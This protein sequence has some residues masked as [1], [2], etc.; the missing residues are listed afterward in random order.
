MSGS[1]KYMFCNNCGKQGHMFHRCK[2][3]ITSIGIIAFRINKGKRE[4][5]MICRRNSLGYVD[6]MRG[7][8][9]LTNKIYIQNII[10]EMTNR[11]KTELLECN[12]ETLWKGLWGEFVGCQYR[13]EEK[14]SKDK[15]LQI[16]HNV[17]QF[18]DKD[19]MTLETLINNSHT[20]W[21][22]P[23]WGFP[24]G[25]RN[26]QENDLTCAFREFEEETGYRKTNVNLLKNVIPFEEIFTGSNMRSYKH[27]Y[28]IGYMKYT[29]PVPYTYQQSEVSKVKWLDLEQCLTA[30]RP[31][32]LEKIEII[33][34]IDEVLDK[35]RLIL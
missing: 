28:Y 1:K 30:I 3:P 17:I 23:E 19:T 35:Y 27:K 4:Y 10:N 22:E 8:Y 18:I 12:F 13:G 33:K 26:Y 16:K 20:N 2:K 14:T 5:L 15:F 31:Y 25:R 6:F 11:E 9:P 21:A 24:K 29:E 34:K 7:K 32:N